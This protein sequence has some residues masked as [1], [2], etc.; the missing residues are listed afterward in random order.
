MTDGVTPK[1]FPPIEDS[2]LSTDYFA[3]AFGRV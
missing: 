1:C 3:M 2:P